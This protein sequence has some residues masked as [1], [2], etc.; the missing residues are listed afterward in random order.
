MRRLGSLRQ[1]WPF[2]QEHPRV[3]R[4]RHDQ[5]EPTLV[6]GL[7]AAGGTQQQ[8]S[9]VPTAEQHLNRVPSVTGELTASLPHGGED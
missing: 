5:Q 7:G 4:A 1:G 2:A 6:K 9:P 3:V 8:M